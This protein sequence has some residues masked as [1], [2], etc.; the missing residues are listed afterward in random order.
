METGINASRTSL[1]MRFFFFRLIFSLLGALQFFLVG[2]G[3]LHRGGFPI[4]IAFTPHCRRISSKENKS[5]AAGLALEERSCRPPT[6][7]R[8]SPVPGTR[9]CLSWSS[10]T[11]CQSSFYIRSVLVSTAHLPFSDKHTHPQ[12]HTHTQPHACTVTVF[13]QKSCR[14]SEEFL[15]F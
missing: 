5:F 12:T 7:N 14:V 6:Q 13:P 15:A 9:H 4:K 3:D 10:L 8:N 2:G 1:S 11:R